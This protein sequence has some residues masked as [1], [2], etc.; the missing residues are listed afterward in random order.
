L[1]AAALTQGRTDMI[2]YWSGQNAMTL[3][4]RKA[5]ELMQALIEE[6]NDLI[7]V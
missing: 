6:T 2:S 4:H 3:K 5:G 1:K 7:K